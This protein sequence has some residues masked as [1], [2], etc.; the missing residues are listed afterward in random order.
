[1]VL[2]LQL[3]QEP[4][5]ES[6]EGHHIDSASDWFYHPSLNFGVSAVKSVVNKEIEN[7]LVDY[8]RL[9]EATSK[10]NQTHS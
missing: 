2:N 8:S 7:Q 6:S 5:G 9:R 1:M 3:L 10:P 4:N